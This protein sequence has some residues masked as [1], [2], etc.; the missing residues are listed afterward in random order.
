MNLSLSR[1]L[2][3]V[4]FLS[5]AWVFGCSSSEPEADSGDDTHDELGLKKG[6]IDHAAIVESTTMMLAGTPTDEHLDPYNQED[7]F[8]IRSDKYADTFARRLSQF[9]DYD[10][11][12]DWTP[13]Q[14]RGW[15]SRMS[16]GNYLVVDTSKPCDFA[17]P[18]TYLE[19]E[20]AQMLGTEHQTCGGRNPNE[21]V[22]DVTINFLVR[23][24]RANPDD[25]D[26]IH[27]GVGQATHKSVDTFPYL[28]EMNGI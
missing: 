3:T 13:E 28:H 24:P 26:G 16:A 23:G 17:N 7:P 19:I 1:A 18:H 10:G 2:L 6:P 4:G 12:R 20:R 15:V 21:D 22:L 5:V 11:K 8:A 27:D 9:D 25:A 14:A